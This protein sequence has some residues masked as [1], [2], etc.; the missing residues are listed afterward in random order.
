[1]V[2]WARGPLTS[3]GRLKARLPLFTEILGK[4]VPG[5]R[6]AALRMAIRGDQSADPLPTLTGVVGNTTRS[7]VVLLCRQARDAARAQLGA[8]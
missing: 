7:T 2:C 8:I 1:M 6:Y 4:I 5:N 3:S